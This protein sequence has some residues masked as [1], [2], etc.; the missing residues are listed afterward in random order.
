MQF[1]KWTVFPVMVI[2]ISTEIMRTFVMYKQH[3]G[4]MFWSRWFCLSVNVSGSTKSNELSD[5]CEL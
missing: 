4:I 2:H 1:Y 3:L 5:K